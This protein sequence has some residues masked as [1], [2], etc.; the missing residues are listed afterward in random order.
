MMRTDPVSTVSARP[1]SAR[2]AISAVFLACG[3]TVGAW[4][5]QLP[6]IKEALGMSDTALSFIVLAFACG[7]IPVMPLAG[8]LVTRWG[9]VCAIAVASVGSAA[10]MQMLGL[11][12]SF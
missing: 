12:G 10:G 3:I 7:S 4:A 11:A 8:V 9:G 5:S 2:I 6:R 1:W